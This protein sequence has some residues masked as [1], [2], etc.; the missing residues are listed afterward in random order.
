MSEVMEKYKELKSP[1]ILLLSLS[2][3]HSYFFSSHPTGT[4]LPII[5][6]FSWLQSIVL[7]LHHN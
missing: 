3:V 6:L 5:L 4:P 1:H 2:D 7:W